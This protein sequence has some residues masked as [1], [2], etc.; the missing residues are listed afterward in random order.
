MHDCLII[1]KSIGYRRFMTFWNFTCSWGAF[2]NSIF[3][4]LQG[5][6]MLNMHVHTKAYTRIPQIINQGLWR[7]FH[8][9]VSNRHLILIADNHKDTEANVWT[10]SSKAQN[11]LLF[12]RWLKL[13]SQYCIDISWSYRY[14]ISVDIRA[15]HWLPGSKSSKKTL[16]ISSNLAGFYHEATE[17]SWL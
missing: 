6:W 1:L 16:Q 14:G 10:R 8:E 11:Q 3:C 5:E 12:G 4:L 7:Q 2:G 15:L 17:N 9:M 13:F